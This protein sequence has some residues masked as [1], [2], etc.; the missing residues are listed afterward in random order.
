[1]SDAAMDRF[2]YRACLR[3]F[4]SSEGVT[5]SASLLSRITF[6]V[7]AA[8]A[9]LAVAGCRSLDMGAGNWH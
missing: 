3:H 6:W 7:A 4:F 1:M 2:P 8:L 9:A 5:V